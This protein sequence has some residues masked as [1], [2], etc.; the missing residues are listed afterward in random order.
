M[1]D[2]KTYLRPTC[3]IVQV[4]QADHLLTTS[5]TSVSFDGL[6]ISVSNLATDAD[7]RSKNRDDD[8]WDFGE[9]G[10]PTHGLW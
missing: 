2:K 4:A 9:M 5:I 7:L 3:T 1:T 8:L 6:S 10:E